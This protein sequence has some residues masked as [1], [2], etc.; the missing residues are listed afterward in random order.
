MREIDFGSIGKEVCGKQNIIYG[1]GY[2]GKALYGLLYDKSVSVEAF[3]DDDRSRWGD[4]C[5]GRKILSESE[6]LSMDRKDTN[7]FISSMYVGQ[8]AAKVQKM[9]FL[10]VFVALDILLKKDTDYFQFRKYGSDTNYIDRLNCLV[11]ASCDKQTKSYFELIK[12]TVLHGKALRDIM[13]LYCGEKQYFLNCFKGKL[14]G[15][16]FLDAGAYTG[17]TVREILEEGIYPAG[18]YCFE[19][20]YDNYS[21]LK[22]FKDKEGGRMNL[23]C[24][25]YAL[26]DCRTRLGMK[27]SNY[28][29]RVDLECRETSVETVTIDDYFRDIK[30]GFI[31]MDIEGAE[32]KALAGGMKTIERDRPILAVSIYHGLDDMVEIPEMLMGRLEDYSFIVRHHSYTYS[33]TILYGA[34]KEWGIF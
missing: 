1:A 6:L 14:N 31:K 25:N 22:V 21:K 20:D 17:D 19:A 2:N 24:E 28:N 30:V 29:A 33:E 16:N 34:P 32:R 4:L 5:C 10:N 9:G 11:E 27:L 15:I 3:Y 23:V 26:W 12:K 7:I 13:D 18:V 8:I